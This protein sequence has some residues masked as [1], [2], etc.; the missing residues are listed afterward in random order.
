[1]VFKHIAINELIGVVAMDKGGFICNVVT[2]RC[3]NGNTDE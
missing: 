1:M 2:G 3:K